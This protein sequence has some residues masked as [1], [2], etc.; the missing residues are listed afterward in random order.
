MKHRERIW[1]NYKINIRQKQER[2]NSQEQT[3]EIWLPHQFPCIHLLRFSPNW[4]QHKTAL[5]TFLKRLCSLVVFLHIA[6]LG[7][8]RRTKWIS[9]SKIKYVPRNILRNVIYSVE[10]QSH[11][12]KKFKRGQKGLMADMSHASFGL[13]CMK[14]FLEE[15]YKKSFSLK[16]KILAKGRKELSA[17]GPAWCS[18]AI[19]TRRQRVS[20]G[21]PHVSAAQVSFIA[22]L[23]L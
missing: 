8:V 5:S 22:F 12:V 3:G 4:F 11:E 19:V 17:L 1:G 6:K 9:S 20:H 23:L 14:L 16:W 15:W 18:Q 2:R 10:E 13:K 21:V 7:K